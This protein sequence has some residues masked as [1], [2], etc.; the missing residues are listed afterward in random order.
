MAKC[1]EELAPGLAACI[2]FLRSPHECVK[3]DF[4]SKLRAKRHK[5]NTK[6]ER[7]ESE[8]K[9]GTDGIVHQTKADN[10]YSSQKT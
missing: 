6:M 2:G 7:G 1:L 5:K 3:L 4:I 9:N 10:E 8:G